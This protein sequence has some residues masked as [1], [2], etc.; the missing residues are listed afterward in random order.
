VIMYRI[1]PTASHTL[2]D[3]EFTINAFAEVAEKLKQGKYP[4]TFIPKG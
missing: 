4:K 2:E 1:I 3:A